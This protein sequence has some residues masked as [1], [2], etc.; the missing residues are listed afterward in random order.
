LEQQR[1]VQGASN[2]LSR[3]GVDGRDRIVLASRNL[4]GRRFAAARI[5]GDAIIA[6]ADQWRFATNYSS[7]RQKVQR[8]FAAEFLVPIEDLDTHLNGSY[9][10]DSIE[11]AAEF[12]G[13]SPMMIS[14]H[15]A[16]TGHISRNHPAL[17][18][19]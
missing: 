14:S 7:A 18:G 11:G 8:A 15:L 9:D 4:P 12:F 3:R 17:Q 19:G 6:R 1:D 5:V 10:E 16:N 13:V 2:S